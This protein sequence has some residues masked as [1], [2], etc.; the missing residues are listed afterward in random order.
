MNKKGF[1]LVELLS[2]IVVLAVIMTIAVP[3]VMGI[4]GII[5]D[6]MLETKLE[7]LEEAAILY[8]QDIKG[9]VM[10]SASKYKNYPCKSY[11]VSDLVPNYLDKDNNNDCLTK[12]NPTGNGCIVD[13][14]DETK[15]LDTYEVIVYFQ[16]KRIKAVVDKDNK[17]S[18][19]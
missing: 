17:L 5:K 8:G 2:V 7:L 16:N 18:C 14:R 19:S 4:N 15:Y 6:N 10:Y 11:I 9:S 12:S 3:S 1:T 13:P